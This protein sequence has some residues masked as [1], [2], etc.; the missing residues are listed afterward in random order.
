MDNQREY[1]ASLATEL[2][3]TSLDDWYRVSMADLAALGGTLISLLGG[4]CLLIIGRLEAGFVR[5]HYGSSLQAALLAIYPSHPWETWK[6]DV[7]RL[8][9]SSSS[10]A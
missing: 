8:K 3:V 1:F 9:A 2:R 5:R 10:G 6:F 7:H 4:H